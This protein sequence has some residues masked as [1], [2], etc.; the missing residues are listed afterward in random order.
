MVVEVDKLATYGSK[1]PQIITDPNGNTANS[2]TQ[3]IRMTAEMLYD[4]MHH[5]HAAKDIEGYVQGGV[6]ESMRQTIEELNTKVNKQDQTISELKNT[7]N[8]QDQAI[9]KMVDAIKL[10]Q[11]TI[12]KQQETIETYKGSIDNIS[13]DIESMQDNSVKISDWDATTPGIQDI[14]GNTISDGEPVHGTEI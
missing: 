4:I 2:D 7:I 14:D 3:I 12:D 5:T 10:Q 11:Q 8:L 13:S 1:Y 9:K 6:D